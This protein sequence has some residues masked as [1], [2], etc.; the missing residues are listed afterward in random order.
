MPNK[1]QREK[2]RLEGRC[3][4]CGRTPLVTVVR[5]AKCRDKR[6]AAWKIMYDRRKDDLGSKRTEAW[7][8]ANPEKR[9]ALARIA[10]NVRKAR[11][12]AGGKFT[13]ADWA[14][15]KERQGGACYD[16]GR[17]DVRL[18]IGHLLPVCKGGTNDLA[19]IVA[20]CMPCNR[21][22]GAS[23]HPSLQGD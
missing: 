18:S 5:C 9:L 4:S 15:V 23:T 17:T 3:I 22:Q 21:R 20:Q 12:R 13:P 2:Y 6:Q 1:Q 10:N 14:K 7:R 11:V 19:N 8:K 16:C